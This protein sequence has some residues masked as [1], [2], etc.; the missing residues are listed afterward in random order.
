MPTLES[1]D[2]E[3][4][5]VK[6]EKRK[7]I[8]AEGKDDFHFFCHACKFYRNVDDVQVMN[9]KGI[10]NLSNYLMLL[11]NDESYGE[12]ETIVIARDAETDASS[13]FISM[14]G[15]VELANNEKSANIPKPTES[16]AYVQND[17]LKTAF[18]IFS[19][20]QY[21]T[22]ALEDLCLLT[23]END[24]LLECVDDY[25]QCAKAKGEQFRRIHKN[26]LHSF[27]AG[28]NDHAGSPLSHAFREKVWRPD[29]P[30]LEPFKMIIQKM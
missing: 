7:L 15:S 2:E 8:L 28:K 26:K 24:P 25:L 11:A 3:Q 27:L 22:G 19:G 30:A 29:H 6:I 13:A 9:F 1:I 23:V 5:I 18:M 14:Q 20:P 16:F 4:A 21:N 17:S 12:V 10:D